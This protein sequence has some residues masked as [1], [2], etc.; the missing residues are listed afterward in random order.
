MIA[1][2]SIYLNATQS[3]NTIGRPPIWMM[4]Q[5][6]RYMPTYRAIRE[7]H[8]F[9]EMIRTP[10][11]ATDITL[12]P[13]DQ[14]GFDAAILFSDILV[15][16]EVLGRKVEFVEKK[17]PIFDRAIRTMADVAELFTDHV[18]EKLAYVTSAIRLLK[19]ELQKRNTPLIGFAG[20][21]FTVAAYMVEGQSSSDLKILKTMLFNDPG[22]VHALLEKLTKV[23]IDYLNAQIEA[24]VDALQLFDTWA[25]HL[26]WDDVQEFS[27][28]YI[29]KI[30]ENLHNPRRIP[31]TLFA[32][33][34]SAFA[35]LMATMPI[36]VISLDWNADLRCMR[37]QYPQLAI[38]GN[39]DP[40]VLYAS[41]D[42][43]TERISRLLGAMG[44]DPGY[45]FNLGH[46]IMPDMNPESIR[47]V[48]DIVKGYRA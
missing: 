3:L 19:P 13:I 37:Q 18:T 47:R 32:K 42:I 9:L 12:Q 4:R 28:N 24:G 20:A 34:S 39:L 40:Y 6:G 27:F 46:G 30:L 11:I 45:V 5:A 10:E 16:A 8:T 33:G 2:D 29:H 22:T 23:T 44:R 31:I 36:D 41:P 25:I 26:S 7:K 48:V 17:G 38:Q 1:S 35:P 15:T 43:L 14:F 21:P